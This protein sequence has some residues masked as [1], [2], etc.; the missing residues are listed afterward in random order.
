MK[1]VLVGGFCASLIVGLSACNNDT[2]SE[3]TPKIAKTETATA[4][5]HALTSGIDFANFD[6]SVRPQDNFYSY[7][8]G[9][10]V[11]NTV[12]PSDRTSTGAF[13]DLREK[14]RDDVKAIIEEVAA[15]VDLKAGSDEQK[16]ADLYR[17][18]MDV[19]TLNK[20]GVTPIESE[21]AKVNAIKDK[22]EL[23]TYFARS[24]IIGGGTPM[25]F[26]IGVDAKTQAVMQLMFGNTG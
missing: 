14:S 24:Q 22:A 8:N 23:V 26:Y 19:E 15:T 9:T 4:V 10:W 11:K 5:H 6:K 25:A 21:L 7:V 20:L 12:I 1:K 13:Y 18:F 2:M 17:S 16:V 3:E